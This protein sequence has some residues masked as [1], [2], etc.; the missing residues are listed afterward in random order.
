MGRAHRLTIGFEALRADAAA[1]R[2]N[3]RN[4]FLRVSPGRRLW[5]GPTGTVAYGIPPG[6][7][8]GNPARGEAWLAGDYT[9]PGAIVRDSRGT[10]NHLLP[11]QIN[12]P[13]AEWRDGLHSFHW[14]CDL[15]ALPDATG[16]QMSRDMILHWVQAGYMGRKKFMAPPVVSRRLARWNLALGVLKAG[17][18]SQ[19]LARINA[20]YTHQAR[21]LARTIGQIPDGPD[22]LEAAIGLT[23]AG[24][25]LPQEGQILRQGMDLLIRELRRQILPDG[26]HISRS[27][28]ILVDLLADLIAIES[29]LAARQIAPPNLFAITLTRMQAMVRMLRHRDKRLAVFQGGIECDVPSLEAVLPKKDQTPMSFAPKS[30]Y[31]R[32]DAEQTTVLVDTGGEMSGPHSLKSHPAPLAFEMS[33]G[34]DRLI[35]NCGPN[36]VHGADWKLAARGLSAHSTLSFDQGIKDPFLRSG[37]AARRLGPRLKADDW[38]VTARRVEDKTGIWFE[39]SHGIFLE[40]HGVRHNRRL[41]IDARGEDFRGEDLLLADMNHDAAEGAPFHLRFHLHPEVTASL[42]SGGDAV[43]LL[44]P[45]GHGWQFRTGN[46]S[47][48]QLRLEESVYMGHN[49]V[50][51]RSQQLAIRGQL[52]HTDTLIRW[53]L[54][55]A[56]RRGKRRS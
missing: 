1:F 40:T 3:L 15:L 17:F 21:W 23:L 38:Q 31:Q 55:Y 47:S 37:H 24:L 34:S 7:R 13:N 18:D 2:N 48:T 41:F 54:R 4:T 6:L 46:D 50:P 43:L 51:Q 16:H 32:L 20:C 29:G 19:E 52:G 12:P 25:S 27:P 28:D 9:L 42:Q 30:G 36:L 35:V 53:A 22:R 26:G 5:Q 39:A 44:T 14:L 45:S 49:G 33:H 56:G 10:D 11:F 8:P